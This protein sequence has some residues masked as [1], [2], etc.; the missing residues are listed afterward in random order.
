MATIVF[1]VVEFRAAFPEFADDT[2]YPDALLQR[3]WDNATCYVSDEDYGCLSGACRQQAI[4]L[5]T[6]HLVKIEEGI[7]S[8]DNSSFV[9]SA[10]ID[11]VSV[12]VVPPPAGSQY[13]WWLSLTPYGQQLLALLKSKTVGGLYVSGRPEKSAFRK[14]GGFF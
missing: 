2:K 8:G 12:T 4:D 1:D 5:M 6:A 13:A 7:L 11:K 10:T 9:Q 3:H 14:V